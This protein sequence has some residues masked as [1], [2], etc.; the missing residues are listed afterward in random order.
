MVVD[1]FAL[2]LHQVSLMVFSGFHYVSLDPLD[3]LTRDHTHWGWA[4][5]GAVGAGG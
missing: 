5:E 3:R 2:C 4:E 1:R